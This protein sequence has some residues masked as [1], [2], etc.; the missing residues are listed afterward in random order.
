M[1]PR[2]KGV[3]LLVPLLALIGLWMYAVAQPPGGPGGPGG[4]F[5]GMAMGTV[6][7]VQGNLITIQMPNGQ[8]RQVRITGQTRLMRRERVTVQDIKPG[9]KVQLRGRFDEKG[10]WF[11]PEEVNLGEGATESP[12]PFGSLTG[13][14]EVVRV[15]GN[16]VQIVLNVAIQN[17]TN[18]YRSRTIQ[19]TEIKPGERIFAVGQ[20]QEGVVEAR[21]ITVGELPTFGFGRGPGGPPGGGRRGGGQQ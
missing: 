15:Q 20:P 12:L 2:V 13:V 17:N 5:G 16:Q 19:A 1:K 11:L 6:Q 7:S 21:T 18:L 8:T 9:A 10:V 4:F 3:V 14:G